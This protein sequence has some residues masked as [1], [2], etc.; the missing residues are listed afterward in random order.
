MIDKVNPKMIT[1]ARES[2]G[3]SQKD[4]AERLDITTAKMS[5][6]EMDNPSVSEEL[7]EAFSK[8]LNYPRSFF[9]QRGEAIPMSLNF[10]KRQVVAQ[11]LIM[12]IEAQINIYRLNIEKFFKSI[13]KEAPKIPVLDLEKFGSP[14]N[15]AKELRKFWKLAKGPISNLMETI[16]GKGII[17]LSFEFGTERVDSRTI[18]T[19]DK[20]PI[21]VLNKSLLG[22]RLRFSLAYELGQLVMHTYTNPSFERDISHEANLFAAEFLMPEKDIKPDLEG[23]LTIPRL[24]ELKRKWK[25][26]MQSILYRANDLE[27]I[28][29]N[30]KRYL[31]E[32]FNTLNIRRREP[33]EL[34]VPIEKPTALRDLIISF[35][36]KSKKSV[37]E[38]ADFF[39]LERED[40]LE[41]YSFE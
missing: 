37:K 1:L 28:S 24:A 21:I 20:Q 22:D 9:N 33:A 4:L 32:Q 19:I 31:L 36:N 38:V 25:V 11:K 34:D 6:V 29:D 17:V 8:A 2:R 27:I 10:R 14:E 15:A 35:K 30:Q 39:N 16:E 5:R 12:P 13:G 26:S 23:D 40:F 7:M 41:K 3:L 18:L